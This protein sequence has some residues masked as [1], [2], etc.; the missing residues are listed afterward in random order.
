MC[1][2]IQYLQSTYRKLTILG[3][4]LVVALSSSLKSSQADLSSSL[5]VRGTDIDSLKDFDPQLRDLLETILAEHHQLTGEIIGV[6]F[7]L[8]EVTSPQELY[9]EFIASFEKPDSKTSK[10]YAFDA[11]N[12]ALLVL[13][14]KSKAQVI[15]GVRMDPIFAPDMTSDLLYDFFY[16]S[17]DGSNQTVFEEAVTRTVIQ[18]LKVLES[19]L[20]ENGRIKD[21][22][23]SA[24]YEHILL[25]KERWIETRT[26]SNFFWFLYIFMGGFGAFLIYFSYR[27]VT[28]KEIHYSS[29]GMVRLNPIQ[30]TFLESRKKIQAFLKKSHSPSVHPSLQGAIRDW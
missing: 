4:F 11:D 12:G 5:Y 15:T 6:Y 20:H 23:D 21:L 17:L 18:I 1:F 16:T 10:D 24:N 28:R 26:T 14:D 7:Q 29:E 13:S 25:P 30:Q 19:P 27:A 9:N 22:F 8:G 2:K 3:L